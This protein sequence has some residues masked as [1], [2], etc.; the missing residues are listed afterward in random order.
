MSSPPPPS[1]RPP[2]HGVESAAEAVHA[3]EQIVERAVVAAERSLARRI[4][5]RGLRLIL[6]GLRAAGVLAILAYFAFGAAV[7]VTRYYLL[8]HIGDWRTT[9][10]TTASNALHAPVTIGAIEADWQ[11]LHP[12][13]RLRDVALQDAAGQTAL[14]L[15]QVDVVVAWTTLVAW[16]ARMQSLTILAPQIEI[17]RMANGFFSV[18][19]FVIDPRAARTDTAL[20]DWV[21]AQHYIRVRDARVHFVD[22]LPL[23]AKIGAAAIAAANAPVDAPTAPGGADAG[24]AP[25][26]RAWDFTD[27]NFLLTRG[28][29]GHHFSLQLRPPADLAGPLDLRG[30]F[31]HAWGEPAARM[32]A[33][34]GRVFL[35]FDYAD[36]ARLDALVHL[37]P[38]PARLDRAKGA[39]RSWIEFSQGE[40]TRLRADVALN[41]VAAQLRPNLEPMRLDLLQGRITQTVWSDG[42]GDSREVALT[43]LRLDG[44]DN[45]HLPPS[46]LLYRTTRVRRAPGAGE[47]GGAAPLDVSH[48][49][50]SR[51]VLSDWSRLARQF[52]LPENWLAVIERTAARGTLEDLHATWGGPDSPAREYALR[53]R[54]SGLGFSLNTA[55]PAEGAAPGTVAPAYQFENLA[56]LVDLTQDVGSLRIDA[57]NARLQ[58]RPVFD[59]TPLDLDTLAAR[60]RWQ[61]GG[62]SGLRLDIDSLSAAN[63]D[64]DLR[65]SGSYRSGGG[66][67]AQ[68]DLNGRVARARVKAVPK[69]LPGKLLTEPARAWLDG[70]LLDGTVSDGSFVLRGD[71]ARFPYVDPKSGNFHVALRVLDGKLDVAPVRPGGNAAAHWPALSGI[72]ADVVFDRNHLTVSG[73]RAKAYGFDLSNISARIP[74]L[75]QPDQHLFVDGQGSGSLPEALRYVVDS[76]VNAWTG[77]WLGAAQASGTAR[78]RLKLDIPMGHSVDTTVAGSVN[79]RDDNLV[80]WPDIGAFSVVNGQ[81]DFT[82]KGIRLTGITAGFLGGDVRVNADTRADGTIRIQGAGTATSQGLRRQVQPAALRRLLDRTRGQMRYNAAVTVLHGNV[83]VQVDSD[84]LG[85][86]ADLPEPFRKT[87]GE[88]RPLHAESIPVAGATPARDTVRATLGNTLAIELHRVAGSNDTMRVER[89]VISIGAQANLPDSGLLLFVDQP[90]VDADR[91]QALLTGGTGPATPAAPAAAGAPAGAVAAASGLLEDN[92]IDLIALHTPSLTFLGKTIANVSLSARRDAERNWVA[93]VDSDQASGSVRWAPPRGPAAGTPSAASGRL[94]ARLAKLVIPAPNDKAGPGLLDTPPTEFPALDIVADEFELGPRKLGRLEIEAQNT[95]GAADAWNLQKLALS[96]PDGKLSASGV[97]QRDGASPLRKMAVK[98][99]LNYA[100][101]GGLLDRFG[102]PGTVKNGSGKLEGELSWRGAPFA[103]DYAS[104]NGKLRLNAEKG[105]FVKVPVGGSA[106]LLGVLSLQSLANRVTGDFRDVFSEGFSFDT[107][108]ASATVADGTLTTDDFIMK[109]V[110]AVVRIKGD[111]DMHAETQ[112]LQVVVIPEINAGTASLAYALVNPAIGLGSFVANLVLRKPLS[113]AFTRIYEVT[114]PWSNPQVKRVHT[115][116][117]KAGDAPQP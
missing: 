97:W 36:L 5:M 92:P 90:R 72:D 111:A 113:A 58:I 50:A 13:L 105:Q 89:G 87:A 27:V 18:A 106:R 16:Q 112:N 42:D 74:Q 95:G 116:T 117:A 67:A 43:G 109:G 45:L 76:P 93:D 81:L 41:D 63:A 61:L 100:N 96:N 103:I 59:E 73:R 80:L 32:T 69:Y 52:P 24:G 39:L 44:P 70:A 85:L 51:I 7:L 28:L 86:A 91:W 62:E 40:V 60:I 71:P 38:A 11:G 66:A 47:A 110:N 77:N 6:L 30:V 65:V 8:P 34:S 49:E 37:V 83:G 79:F 99:S 88:V 46:D 31:R 57:S 48:F 98:V 12:R 26:T 33:W 53:T 1:P 115:E 68:I 114:G 17:R 19:G 82:Q 4:G 9:I 54:F 75:D 94:T 23:P 78:L 14:A 2:A 64:A 35:Q 101:A 108:S 22:E 102:I 56:G 20:L 107:L 104:L 29:T 21:L 10:E 55:A 84:L 15:P 3:A 25:D